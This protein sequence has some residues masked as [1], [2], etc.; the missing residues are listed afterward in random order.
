M[1]VAEDLGG[2]ID[3][4]AG[5]CFVVKATPMMKAKDAMDANKEEWDIVELDGAVMGVEE[6]ARAEMDE[7]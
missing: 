4:G 7:E 6:P 2:E 3:V 1:L 5:R